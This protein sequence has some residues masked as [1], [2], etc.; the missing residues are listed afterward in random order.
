M[1][2][3]NILNVIQQLKTTKTNNL[4][5][6]VCIRFLFILLQALMLIDLDEEDNDYKLLKDRFVVLFF[7]KSVLVNRIV[8][9]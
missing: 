4:S 3:L 6:D 9:L 7:L 2:R 8:K 1:N 5:I